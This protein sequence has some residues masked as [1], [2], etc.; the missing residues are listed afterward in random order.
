MYNIIFVFFPVFSFNNRYSTDENANVYIVKKIQMWNNLLL[1]NL[2]DGIVLTFS[3]LWK[4]NGSKVKMLKHQDSM[5]DHGRY[6]WEGDHDI[7]IIGG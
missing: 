5:F 4:E 6:I 3:S 1:F 7:L 2:E